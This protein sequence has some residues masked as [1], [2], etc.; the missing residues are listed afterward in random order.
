MIK[1]LSTLFILA[2]V[3]TATPVST[4]KSPTN[5][6]WVNLIEA[7]S[8]SDTGLKYWR[9]VNVAPS[10]FSLKTDAQGNQILACSGTPAGTIRS[11][12]TYENFLVEFDWK[13]ANEDSSEGNAI[14]FVCSD[15]LPAKNSHFARSIE[16][17]APSFDRDSKRFL[18]PGSI[19]AIH[20]AKISPDP[21]FA[22]NNGAIL[23][24]LPIPENQWVHFR[25]LCIDGVIELEVNGHM[26]AGGYHASPRK[27]HIMLGST[28]DKSAYKNIRIL[29]L[30]ANKYKLSIDD[31]ATTLPASAKI[32]NL[33]NG[34][35]LKNWDKSADAKFHC[36]NGRIYAL[37][38]TIST[39]LALNPKT[40]NTLLID[41]MSK[42]QESVLPFRLGDTPHQITPLK[43][44]AHR[45]MID[46]DTLD[47][48]LDGKLI[49]P[50]KVS[51]N[52]NNK[53]TLNA[54]TG[55]T[56][57]TNLLQIE[58]LE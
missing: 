1:K 36:H 39:T 55:L 30:P 53:L 11:R 4:S 2:Q 35:D 9:N 37:T 6:S 32:K 13:C 43:A 45:A 5:K 46:L 10:T 49:K 24:R 51:K 16:I 31:Q 21:R 26:V 44:G 48:L 41:W 57:F 25:I 40:S 38:G 7:D 8:H 52:N 47:C 15:G 17:H 19:N 28:G 3:L 29:P 12:D 20:G 50:L 58:G 27:G 22:P 33:H 14:F 23:P 42:K 18:Q 54:L 56:V 34:R